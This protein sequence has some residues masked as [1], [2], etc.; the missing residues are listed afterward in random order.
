MFVFIF[1]FC[2][3]L[4]AGF[5]PDVMELVFQVL[6]YHSELAKPGDVESAA[7]LK[8]IYSE[9]LLKQVGNAMA[10]GSDHAVKYVVVKVGFGLSSPGI[11]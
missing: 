1:C 9:A 4:A 6:E 10:A 2:S 7:K 5:N 3:D 11:L 8:N